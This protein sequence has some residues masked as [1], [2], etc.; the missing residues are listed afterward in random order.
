MFGY[1]F[2]FVGVILYMMQ[3]VAPGKYQTA[4]YAF[5]T[6]VMQLG[7]VL[8]KWVS[9]NIQVALGYQKF[10]IWVLLSAIPV[11]VLSQLIPMSSRAAK[12]DEAAAQQAATAG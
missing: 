1:G 4:H 3:V 11:L 10:F 2:G 8:F 12:D 9:G 6:G 5:S 7:F